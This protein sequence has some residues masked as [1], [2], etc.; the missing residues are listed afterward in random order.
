[1]I[2]SF[3][4]RVLTPDCRD[5]RSGDGKGYGEISMVNLSGFVALST[6]TL[7]FY[8][9]RAMHGPLPFQGRPTAIRRIE[10]F[11]GRPMMVR[12]SG[13]WERIE[14]EVAA[15]AAAAELD[16]LRLVNGR[17]TPSW[18]AC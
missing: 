5:C 10:I 1:M 15:A 14:R 17:R 11:L 7:R 12:H 4:V 8:H 16:L 3:S 9:G 2:C 18:R 13:C 6:V